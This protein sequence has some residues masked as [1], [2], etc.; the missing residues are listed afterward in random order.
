MKTVLLIGLYMLLGLGLYALGAG[1]LSYGQ[2][3]KP[4]PPFSWFAI[5]DRVARYLLV[6]FAYASLFHL[7][8]AA[9]DRDNLDQWITRYTLR[10][11]LYLL[12]TTVIYFLVAVFILALS[13]LEIS[14][15]PFSDSA[16]FNSV[17]ITCFV[18][19]GWAWNAAYFV[20]YL[21]GFARSIGQR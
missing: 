2:V 11:V 5:S 20:K 1:N 9:L 7:I 15:R 14:K 21:R 3:L 18:V 6:C 13:C 8:W 16:I 12:G 17:L 10:D 4:F 19:G